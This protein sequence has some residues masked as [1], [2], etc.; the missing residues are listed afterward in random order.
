MTSR[1]VILI[2]C[3]V[4]GLS[5]DRDGNTDDDDECEENVEEKNDDCPS[6]NN[7]MDE[8]KEVE[9]NFTVKMNELE[10]RHQQRLTDLRMSHNAELSTLKREK[11]ELTKEIEEK[12][13]QMNEMKEQI[14]SL[15]GVVRES[16][17][18]EDGSATNPRSL[19][20]EQRGNSAVTMAITRIV[21]MTFYFEKI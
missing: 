4:F 12:D 9:E 14:R 17:K 21:G 18:K 8:M 1:K 2:I 7:L 11:A 3:L 10:E 16:D 13:K 6:C 19:S 20:D 15:S 5:T